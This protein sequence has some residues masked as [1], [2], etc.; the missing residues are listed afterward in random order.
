MEVVVSFMIRPSV[1]VP[2]L[3]AHRSA[4]ID[5][6]DVVLV[7]VHHVLYILYAESTLTTHPPAIEE[8]QSWC[9]AQLPSNFFTSPPSSRN[10][11]ATRSKVSFPPNLLIA[12][13]SSYVFFSLNWKCL[14]ASS[15]AGL[16]PALTGLDLYVCVLAGSTNIAWARERKP[17]SLSLPATWDKFDLFKTSTGRQL[18]G[19]IFSSVYFYF[20]LF[21]VSLARNLSAIIVPQFLFFKFYLVYQ[22]N[23]AS[24]A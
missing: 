16:T 22:K 2:P 23:I 6:F 20:L 13:L 12:Q 14:W 15:S 8:S 1:V 18:A 10:L 19:N 5:L 21:I 17:Q 7:Y 11:V 4:I 9:C 24:F 3:D